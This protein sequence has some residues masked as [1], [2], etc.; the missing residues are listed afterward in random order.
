MFEVST[1]MILFD[2]FKYIFLDVDGVVLQSIRCVCDILN[3]YYKKDLSPQ[4]IVSWDFKEFDNNITSKEIEDIFDSV[5]FFDNVK[6]YDG[7]IDF[8]NKY[9]HK[10]ICVTKGRDR[11]IELKKQLFQYFCLCLS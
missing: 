2:K 8:I 5:Y 9:E 3:D 1:D 7:V 10:I 11:N 6:F 4:N